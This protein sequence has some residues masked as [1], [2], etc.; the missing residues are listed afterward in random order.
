MTAELARQLQTALKQT[1]RK[2]TGLNET[3]LKQTGLNQIGLNQIGLN[4]TGLKQTALEQTPPAAFGRPTQ[5]RTASAIE[6]AAGLLLT[7]D[8][9]QCKAEAI[10]RALVANNIAPGE[11][12]LCRMANE[13]LD[14]AALLGIWLAGGVAVPLNWAATSATVVGIQQATGA[15][16]SVRAERVGSISRQPPAPRELLREAA[17]IV[18]TSGST[19][20]PKGVVLAHQRLARKLEVLDRLLRF[21]G[22][23]IVIVPLQLSFI[24][25]IWV[26]L[27]SILSGAQL[28]L[29]EKFTA[30]GLANKLAEGASVLAV[31]PTMLRT[32]LAQSPLPAAPNLRS[33]LSGGESLGQQL[34]TSLGEVF[35]RTDIYDLYGLTETGSCDFCLPPREFA[36]GLGSIG[37]PTEAVHYRIVGADGAPVKPGAAGEL[38]LKTPF[39]MLGYLDDPELS[40]AAFV[41]GYLRTGDQAKLRADGRVEIV[42]RL[43]EIISRG[44]NKIAPAEIDALLMRH[45][46]VTGALCAGVTDARLG[47]A[48]GVIVTLAPGAALTADALR[49][50]SAQRI[51]KFKVPDVILI[52]NALPT[53]STGKLSRAAVA[54]LIL[55]GSE[56]TGTLPA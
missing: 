39:G 14:L 4:Q 19:G 6:G 25:G 13:P 2:Q 23:D 3:G 44:G 20:K 49:H 31:V 38:L 7:A 56:E 45:P 37:R 12:V 33:L 36:G 22:D 48:I 16:L 51:E 32:L 18:F 24:F 40:A 53:G 50:W 1:A 43:K 41:E 34:A 54:R 17:L 15:R 26:S 30:A 27:L 42:G 11:P 29:M 8:Q 46:L 9:I 55:A 52:R 28:V 21:T 35:P 10:A 47:E 5:G